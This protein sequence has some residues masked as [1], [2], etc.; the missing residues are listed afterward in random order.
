M[1]RLFNVG[2]DIYLVDRISRDVMRIGGA[3]TGAE[4]RVQMLQRSL[5]ALQM[6]H[7]VDVQHARSLQKIHGESDAVLARRI[8]TMQTSLALNRHQI[9]DAHRLERARIAQLSPLERSIALRKQEGIETKDNLRLQ[10][11]QNILADVQAKRVREN[12]TAAIRNA[13]L[14]NNI[15]RD[16][17]R[18]KER[19]LEV[20]DAERA[21]RTQRL[22]RIGIGVGTA[23]VV[24]AALGYEAVKRAMPVQVQTQLAGEAGG[25][26]RQQTRQLPRFALDIATHVKQFSVGDVMSAMP[27]LAGIL[28]NYQMLQKVAPSIFASAAVMR[29]Y[30][31]TGDVDELVGDIAQTQRALGAR[32]PQQYRAV[33]RVIADAF[34]DLG[35]QLS[36]E[37]IAASLRAVAPAIVRQPF[38]QGLRFAKQLTLLQ[39]LTGVKGLPGLF[40]ELMVPGQ[41]RTLGL[42]GMLGVHNP[43]LVQQAL[44]AGLSGQQAMQLI[45]KTVPGLKFPQRLLMEHAQARTLYALQR[46]MT[47]GV[48]RTLQADMAKQTSTQALLTNALKNTTA[49]VTGL[50][51]SIDNVLAVEGKHLLKPGHNWL[52]R[53]EGT[54]NIA[55]HRKSPLEYLGKQYGE[56]LLHHDIW[57]DER[58]GHY[59]KQGA[60]YV[61]NRATHNVTSGGHYVMSHGIPLYMGPAAPA[62]GLPAYLLPG[63]HPPSTVA[64]PVPAGAPA[65]EGQPIHVTL[66]VD[67]KKLAEATAHHHVRSHVQN[68]KQS[69]LSKGSGMGTHVNPAVA[70]GNP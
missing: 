66:N 61:W 67:G 42:L 51:K 47:G 3:F 6:R 30:G 2:V 44:H 39:G 48:M 41:P 64:P 23:A 32:T 4:R 19:N 33:N 38:N 53:L 13:R 62:V 46:A 31:A 8:A 69:M 16:R 49:A 59:V 7:G 29:V 9:N 15:L 54:F 17:T 27:R 55:A 43:R 60:L 58:I 35:G 25:F 12:E 28:H 37:R 50:T 21:A 57:V 11:E 18:I 40:N 10:R 26:T 22:M 34:T 70:T 24:A 5:N 63:G 52:S 45:L 20:S 36:P 68:L 56:W 14:Q 65:H 1:A